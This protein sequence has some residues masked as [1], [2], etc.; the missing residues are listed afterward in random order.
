MTLKNMFGDLAL[1]DTAMDAK[2]FQDTLLQVLVGMYNKM[3]RLTREGRLQ[4]AVV[5]ASGNEITEPWFGMSTNWAGEPQQG[6]QYSRIFEPQNFMN[7]ASA[8]LY[9]NITVS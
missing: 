6:R 7:T 3:P 8:Y 4:T 2:E 5:S 1:E 9:N